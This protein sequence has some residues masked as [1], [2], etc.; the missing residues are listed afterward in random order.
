MEKTPEKILVVDD[1]PFICE[2]LSRWLMLTGYECHKAGNAEEALVILSSGDF[3]LLISDIN[4]PGKSGI[5]L[6]TLVKKRFRDIAVIMA[7]AVDDR[8]TAI[9]T[10]ELGAYGYIIKPFE[11][12]E[13]IIN[14]ANALHFRA[15]E[16]E[17]RHYSEGLEQIVLT[18]TKELRE[19]I[20]R[21]MKAEEE[22]MRSREETIQRLSKAAEFRDDE[23]AQHTLRMSVY[24]FLLAQK[25][26]LH[27]QR[28]ELIRMASPMHDVGKIGTPDNIL[29]KPG[30]LTPE[31]FEIMKRHCEIGYRILANSNSDLLDLAASIAWTHHE[32]FNGQ[33]YPRG[34]KGAEIPTEGR[35]AAIADVFDALTSDRVYKKAFPVDK[36]VS[37]LE[38][39]RGKH[40]DPELVDLFLGS[41]EEILRIKEQYSDKVDSL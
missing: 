24:C 29:L 3:S 26:G 33:G 37:I 20:K 6:L 25:A 7:T 35:L 19:A 21:Q 14:V 23:T 31:E 1:E 30:R 2:I 5:E 27:P 12:N 18:R 36:A 40:F 38:E 15:L 28:C 13:V 39:E 16:I 4:M 10:L 41:M 34:L 32:K 11:R 22:L 8:K 17:Q 9:H